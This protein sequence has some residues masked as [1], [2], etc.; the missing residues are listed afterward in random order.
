MKRIAASEGI[1]LNEL[2]ILKNSIKKLI[3][4]N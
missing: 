3:N 2:R 1:P 4:K